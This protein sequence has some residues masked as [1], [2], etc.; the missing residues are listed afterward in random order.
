MSQ[1]ADYYRVGVPIIIRIVEKDYRMFENF[2]SLVHFDKLCSY[3]I[4]YCWNFGANS[5]PVS[6]RSNLEIAMR[7]LAIFWI[8]A[9]ER[10]PPRNCCGW[11]SVDG[12]EAKRSQLWFINQQLR[13]TIFAGLKWTG[14]GLQNH[15]SNTSK[16]TE[17]FINPVLEN[18]KRYRVCFFLK[19]F[20]IT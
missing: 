4:T 15:S 14:R 2:H 19:S 12:V 20:H 5:L 3:H 16:Q 7:V 18:P 1:K 9:R 17:G 13:P 11:L 8:F 6:R 10:F